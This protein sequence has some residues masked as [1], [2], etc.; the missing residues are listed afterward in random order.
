MKF[1]ITILAVLA[2]MQGTAKAKEAIVYSIHAPTQE[3]RGLSA[4]VYPGS[5]RVHLK[6]AGNF[7]GLGIG[8]LWRGFLLG[9]EWNRIA[10]GQRKEI[11]EGFTDSIS[12]HG[13]SMPIGYFPWRHDRVAIM[14]VGVVGY[15]S[16]D[17]SW[18]RTD[19]GLL[20]YCAPH[21][22]GRYDSNVI[23]GYGVQSV[24]KVTRAFGFAFGVRYSDE[25][26]WHYTIGI[27]FGQR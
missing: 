14:P 8:A 11:L 12:R 15:A 17:H 1:A 23:L 9:F 25:Q 5:E 22:Q 24:V 26:R 20:D 10:G 4:S 18:E 16:T 27:V 3:P 6:E 13:V 2:T 7:G 19:C 21:T